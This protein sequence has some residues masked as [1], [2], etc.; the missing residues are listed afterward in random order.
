LRDIDVEI[1]ADGPHDGGYAITPLHRGGG[2][3]L[4]I[5]GNPGFQAVL[6]VFI[7]EYDRKTGAVTIPDHYWKDIR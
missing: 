1:P 6:P 3:L 4:S 5:P 7:L 2:L